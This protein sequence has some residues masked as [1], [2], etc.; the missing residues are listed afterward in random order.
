LLPRSLRTPVGYVVLVVVLGAMTILLDRLEA[1]FGLAL[2][3]P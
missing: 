1:Y 2:L 3:V